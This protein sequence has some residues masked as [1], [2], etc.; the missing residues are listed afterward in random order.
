MSGESLSTVQLMRVADEAKPYLF[1]QHP[2]LKEIDADNLKEGDIY[3]NINMLILEYGEY[4]Q[5]IPMHPEDHEQLTPM[6]DLDRLG[7]KGEVIDIELPEDDD[8]PSEYG[9]INW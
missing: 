7:F 1:Q 3:E 8:Q 9:D 4:H 5:V 6:E 2:W